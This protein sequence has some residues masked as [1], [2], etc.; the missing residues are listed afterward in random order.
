MSTFTI[1]S[2]CSIAGESIKYGVVFICSFLLSFQAFAGNSDSTTITVTWDMKS[3]ELRDVLR[4][5]NIDYFS[6]AFTDTSLRGKHFKIVSKEYR[7]SKLIATRDHYTETNYP[8]AFAFNKDSAAFRFNILAHQP[9][10]KQTH[11]MFQ[12]DRVGL[13]PK[14]KSKNTNLYSL[15]DATGSLGEPVQVPLYTS[16][17]LFVYSLPY[18]DPNKPDMY[19]YC[20]LTQ[21][22]V[23][24]SE[25]GKKYGVKHYIVFE[26]QIID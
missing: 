25:W 4:L 17:P 5:Q 7:N 10:K 9:K 21:D 13:N 14:Y 19:Q 12:F 2:F 18:V 11:F 23:P 22:A 3:T 15:R 24:P 20:A 16:F 26:M 8:A 1:V 6:V